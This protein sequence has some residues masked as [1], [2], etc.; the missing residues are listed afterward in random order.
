MAH[1]WIRDASGWGAQRLDGV[2]VALRARTTPVEGQAAASDGAAWLVCADAGGAKAWAL[3]ASHG[4]GVRVN[5]RMPPGGLCVL[6]DRDE[7]RLGGETR[8][9]STETVAAVVEFP[10][11]ER[12]VFCGRCRVQIDART[13]AVCCPA[14]NIWYHESADYRCWTYSES[15]TFCGHSTDLE[16]G[17][18]W[19]PEEG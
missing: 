11:A 2:T 16:R 1:L 7:I 14:C 13:L 3:I 8:Y 9:F 10:G 17:F 18:S 6:A 12:A 5:S 15:C 19:N 4:S